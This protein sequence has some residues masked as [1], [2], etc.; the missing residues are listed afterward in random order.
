LQRDIISNEFTKIKKGRYLGP[1]FLVRPAWAL[2][3]G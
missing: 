1:C 2:A 3:R